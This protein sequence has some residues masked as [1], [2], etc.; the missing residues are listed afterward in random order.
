RIGHVHLKLVIAELI[1]RRLEEQLEDVVIPAHAV[2]LAHVG[3]EV[4]V[5]HFGSEVEIL[6]VP[7]QPRLG[8]SLR[9][10]IFPEDRKILEHLRAPPGRL[11]ELAVQRDRLACPAAL[12][13]TDGANGFVL[14]VRTRTLWTAVRCD[15]VSQ[16]TAQAEHQE[17]GCEAEHESSLRL[18]AS[19]RLARSLRALRTERYMNPATARPSG[20]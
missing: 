5:F 18:K 13:G 14:G 20:S 10:T 2:V 7:Q 15:Q 8:G 12:G 11:V 4:G 1:R 3:I 19:I 17:T 9:Q 6:V 16:K